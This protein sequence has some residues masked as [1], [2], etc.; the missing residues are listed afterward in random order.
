L[1]KFAQWPVPRPSRRDASRQPLD[2]RYGQVGSSKAKVLGQYGFRTDFSFTRN[3]REGPWFNDLPTAK[4]SCCQLDETATEFACQGLE[5][6][7]PIVGW[8]EDLV[9]D[10]AAWTAKPSPRS[11]ARDPAQLRRNSYRVLLTRGRDG[12][13]IFVPPVQPLARSLVALQ[14][15]GCLP[16]T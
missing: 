16:L 3:F 12:M 6:D 2:K 9:F 8:G 10:G 1:R 7:F 4:D 14:E 15:A 11:K 5:L 13:V